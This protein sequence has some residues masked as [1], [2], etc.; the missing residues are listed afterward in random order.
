MRVI[1]FGTA[2]F[3]VPSL[4]AV[5]AH[6]TIVR[7]V[8]QPDR[9][10]GRGLLTAASPVKQVAE[11]LGLPL[12][13]P[14]RVTRELCEAVPPDV[15]IVVAYGR[16][17][18]REVLDAPPQGMV[19][20]HPSPL[21]KCR[22][23]APVTWTILRGDTQTG[24]TI[25]RLNERL[26][27]GDILSVRSTAID[28]S[29]DAQHLTQRLAQ[30]GAEELVRVL[31]R[32]ASGTQQAV[33]QDESQATFAPKLTK[34]QGA[35]D[36]QQPADVIARQVRAM[37]PWPTAMTQWQDV[38]LKILKAVARQP[39]D[40]AARATPGRIVMVSEEAI[41][42]GTGAGT[43]EI[44]EVQPAGRRRMPVAAFLAGHPVRIGD[45]LGELNV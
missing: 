11:R 14:E 12:S 17:I 19:G 7:C 1:F 13:Q 43:L 42:V 18:P 27:A 39:S 6:H 24:V 23:A 36:W 45:K 31:E 21:P 20:V 2:Q 4:E 22:G 26:D 28:A 16:L 37:I 25:F 5:A 8:T 34:A 30:L 29:E 35:I 10:Q 41:S 32:M 44:S 38:E 40:P 3:A 15:G 33:A 9:P